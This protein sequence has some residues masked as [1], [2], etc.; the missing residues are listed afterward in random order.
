MPFKPVPLWYLCFLLFPSVLPG[1][2]SVFTVRRAPLVPPKDTFYQRTFLAEGTT[3][4]NRIVYRTGF[5]LLDEHQLIYF[6]AAQSILDSLGTLQDKNAAVGEYR[7]VVYSLNNDTLMFVLDQVLP[8]MRTR[9]PLHLKKAFCGKYNTSQMTMQVL[10]TS[11]NTTEAPP[12][13]DLIVY[14]LYSTQLL[15]RPKKKD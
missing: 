1:Q 10:T 4:R 6:S 12:L 15:I 13:N 11:D 3:T 7:K 14:K 8:S 5:K 2:D 9:R